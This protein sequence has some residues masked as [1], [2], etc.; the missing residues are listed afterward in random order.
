MPSSSPGTVQ[1]PSLQFDMDHNLAD[2]NTAWQGR[3]VF[4]PYFT[5]TVIKGAWQTWDPLAGKWW[6][7]GSPGNTKCP[8]TTPCTWAKVLQE[9]PNAGIRVSVGGLAFKAGS[10][11]PENFEGYV[12]G[13]VIVTGDVAQAFDFEPAP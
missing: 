8:Q 11:W 5:N 10:G 12:D 3:L 4:E 7:T 9:F 1:A 13:F 6:A 2:T